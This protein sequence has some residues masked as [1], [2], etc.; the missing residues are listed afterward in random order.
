MRRALKPWTKYSESATT[1]WARTTKAITTWTFYCS[2]GKGRIVVLEHNQRTVRGKSKRRVI[3][4]GE[5]KREGKLSAN[6][7]KFNLEGDALYI[8]IKKLPNGSFD[9]TLQINDLSFEEARNCYLV[10]E[11]EIKG[12][13]FQ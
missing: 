7:F 10:S 2:R 11:A 8:N 5:V 12:L 9:Y 1:S 13:G 3:I 6:N 4:D